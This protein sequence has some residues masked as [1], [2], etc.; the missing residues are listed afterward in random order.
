VFDTAIH[1]HSSLKSL[2]RTGA[3]DSGA[4]YMTKA[5]IPLLEWSQI[6]VTTYVTRPAA[7]IMIV[8]IILHKISRKLLTL[9]IWGGVAYNNSCHD[10]TSTMFVF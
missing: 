10:L 3:Y 8:A 1:F 7:Q 5:R 9:I 2:D 6:D 4:P